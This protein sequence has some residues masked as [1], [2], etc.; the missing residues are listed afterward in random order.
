MTPGRTRNPIPEGAI[1]SQTD[2]LIAIHPLEHTLAHLHDSL[3]TANGNWR[4]MDSAYK[5][6]GTSAFTIVK[7]TR[8][9]SQRVYAP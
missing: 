7:C 1:V 6:E 2:R 8:F 5:L 3:V 9:S 4:I